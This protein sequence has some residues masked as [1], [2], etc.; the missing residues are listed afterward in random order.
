MTKFTVNGNPVHFKMPPETPLLWAL[1][2]AS[3]LT[4]TKYGCGAGLC[5]AC[6]VHVDG[7]AARS[8]QVPIGSIEGSFVVTIEGLSDDRSHPVQQ[9]W[10]AEQVPQCGYC[11]SG[12]IM[13]VAAL[14]K[15]NAAPSDADI[16]GAITNICRCGTYPRIRK[17]IHRAAAGAADSG[18]PSPEST[19]AEAARIAPSLKPR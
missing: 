8:C 1:R 17:A 19:A 5:G 2:D 13:A 3:N 18:V 15:E 11:Q 6:T 4:G 14:L 7:K 16:D 12:M 9:A 10:I